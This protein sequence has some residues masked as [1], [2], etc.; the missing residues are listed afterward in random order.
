MVVGGCLPVYAGIFDRQDLP[1]GGT[2][3]AGE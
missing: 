2:R 1:L 3:D